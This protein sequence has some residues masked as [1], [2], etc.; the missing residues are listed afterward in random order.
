[1]ELLM[2]FWRTTV[3]PDRAI[4]KVLAYKFYFKSS[5]NIWFLFGLLGKISPLSP[6]CFGYF[7]A[8]FGKFWVSICSYIWW[9][10][11]T[12]TPYTWVVDHMRAEQSIL[13]NERWWRKRKQSPVPS[14]T[15]EVRH[16]DVIW[17]IRVK[18]KTKRMLLLLIINEWIIW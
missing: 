6:N 1:M 5:P 12:K 8:T 10:W 3:W 14:L 11:C 9:H 16:T 13:V 2:L 18:N 4:L 17:R 15:F 7:W